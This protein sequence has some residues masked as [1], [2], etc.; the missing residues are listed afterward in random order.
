MDAVKLRFYVGIKD[1]GCITAAL[2]DDAETTPK[3]IAEFARNMHKSKRRMEHGELTRSE[4]R[5]IF[6][7]CKH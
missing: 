4:Y 7:N 5:K 3:A 2:L 1:C 6:V